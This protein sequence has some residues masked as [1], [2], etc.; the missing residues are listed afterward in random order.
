M[1]RLGLNLLSHLSCTVAFII[2]LINLKSKRIVCGLF[3]K[4]PSLIQNFG[5]VCFII[6]QELA[7]KVTLI[8]WVL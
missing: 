6:N 8:K 2:L 7:V 3:W 5:I 1:S 4:S